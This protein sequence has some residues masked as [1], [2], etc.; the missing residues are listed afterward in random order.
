MFDR[1]L[2]LR[3]EPG[4]DVGAGRGCGIGMAAC[5]RPA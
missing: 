5:L 4:K 3:R 1:Q 2:T